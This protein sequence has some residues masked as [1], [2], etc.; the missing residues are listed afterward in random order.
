MEGHGFVCEEMQH[1]SRLTLLLARDLSMLLSRELCGSACRVLV[2]ISH[3]REK[4][5]LAQH[6]LN[7]G[8]TVV[9]VVRGY[10][11][12]CSSDLRAR[13]RVCVCVWLG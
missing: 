2:L 9:C 12:L 7:T 1:P 6:W 4:G 13:A 8:S 10:G 3:E 5:T 11:S